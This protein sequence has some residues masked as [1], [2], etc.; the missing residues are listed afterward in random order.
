MFRRTSLLDRTSLVKFRGQSLSY[1]QR[2]TFITETEE[3]GML[4]TITYNS[5]REFN[6]KK[7]SA[8]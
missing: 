1:V 4:P 6:Y 8:S 7:E 5:K 2:F 3:K